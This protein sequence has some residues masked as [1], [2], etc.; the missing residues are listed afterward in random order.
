MSRAVPEGDRSKVNNSTGN[1]RT[2]P[3]LFEELILPHLDAAH[4][5]ARWLTGDAEDAQEVVQEAY[6][7]AFRYFESYRGGDSKAWLLA[8][9]RNTAF[10]FRSGKRQAAAESF[11]ESAHSSQV[12]MQNQEEKLVDAAEAAILRKCIEALPL[13]FRDVLIMRE[14][15]EMS[16]RQISDAVCIPVGTVM[17]RL[18]RARKRL[19]ECTRGAS[20]RSSQ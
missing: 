14:L 12:P 9:V 16:Y 5:L 4:N 2:R 3:A 20:A 18:S 8:I 10:T 11:D 6:L 19:G 7:R 17:S 13:E 1:E 15:E